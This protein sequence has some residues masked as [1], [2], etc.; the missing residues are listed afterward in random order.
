MPAL[1]NAPESREARV[2]SATRLLEVY[3]YSPASIYVAAACAR[4]FQ[5]CQRVRDFILLPKHGSFHRFREL[6]APL[7]LISAKH[8]SLPHFFGLEFS[9]VS[10]YSP[11][12]ANK[13]VL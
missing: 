1:E 3:P 9:P 7:L 4:R 11:P 6:P 13:R 5:A 8:L 2:E 12:S 10:T